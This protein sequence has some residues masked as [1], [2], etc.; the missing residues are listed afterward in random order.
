MKVDAAEVL[1]RLLAVENALMRLDGLA[2]EKC[3]DVKKFA[4]SLLF[5]RKLRLL[6]GRQLWLLLWFA[7]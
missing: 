2:R 3:G 4:L 7:H 1:A 6:L 5:L